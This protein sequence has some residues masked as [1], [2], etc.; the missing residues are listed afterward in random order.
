MKLSQFV[1]FVPDFPSTGRY[2]AYHTLNRA[3]V[4]VSARAKEILENPD[5]YDGDDK[6]KYLKTFRKI[7]FIIDDSIDEAGDFRD[8]YDKARDDKSVVRATILTTYN[9]NFACVYCVE[10][11]VRKPLK[12]DEAGCQNTIDWLIN[13]AEK[14]EASGIHL[15]FYGGEPLMNVMP[16]RRIASTIGEYAKEN[17]LSFSFNITTNGS[18]LRPEL[19]DEL[20]DLGL[21]SV[22]V[23]LDGERDVHDSKRPLKSGKG[24][25]D[26]V[27]KNLL[28]IADKV[29]IQ[30]GTNVGNEDMDGVFRLL[31]YLDQVG[32]KDKIDL[33]K[34]YP[35]VN[36]REHDDT[37]RLTRQADCA[38]AQEKD[39]MSNLITL[40]WDA[41]RRGF[42]TENAVRST[43]C[44]MNRDASAVVIDPLGRIYTCPAF[45]GREGFQVGDIGHE[46]LFDK[47]QELMN[48][49]IPDKCFECA[50]MPMCGGGCRHFSHSKYGDI[51]HVACEKE[52]IANATSETLKRSIL[53][54]RGGGI[55]GS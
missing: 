50:Y 49:P 45:V 47:H 23:T 9:C 31:D 48:I 30:I 42:K 39:V 34:F 21:V 43:I 19:V 29:K 18:L 8:W 4:V 35:I 26:I 3:T 22:R 16:I 36:I 44:S 41:Y 25:F 53:S 55:G 10:E 52:Y 5:A 6:E 20:V 51:G 27:I 46:E 1:I 38:P 33:I 24:S 37:S 28:Q 14:H 2:L 13:R 32:L 17:E 12:M 11:G 54:A 15:H 7:G 40:A